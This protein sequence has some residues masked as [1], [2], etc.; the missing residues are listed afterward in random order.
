[1]RHFFG[2]QAV[3]QRALAFVVLRLVE[4][5][6]GPQLHQGTGAVTHVANLLLE[7]E[8]GGLGSELSVGVD[9]YRNTGGRG[10]AVDASDV[11]SGL[12]VA[13]AE[14]NGVRF[15]RSVGHRSHVSDVHVITACFVKEGRLISDKDVVLSGGVALATESSDV[16]VVVARGDNAG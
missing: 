10:R 16:G 8:G 6:H 9:I 12:V 5:S 15:I 3:L 11:G 4:E 2:D 1:M 7:A 13:I 14:A